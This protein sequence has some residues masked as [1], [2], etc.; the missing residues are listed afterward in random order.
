MLIGKLCFARPITKGISSN[1]YPN[2]QADIYRSWPTASFKIP[3]SLPVIRRFIG[4]RTKL[5]KKKIKFHSHSC[6]IIH[7]Y[8][9]R[10][11][12]LTISIG[13]FKY[14]PYLVFEC[15]PSNSPRRITTKPL[16]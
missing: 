15:P 5:G 1:N 13:N 14:P 6:Q 16:L 10:R 7:L 3:E 8:I 12:F 2:I 4:I 9:K 11:D